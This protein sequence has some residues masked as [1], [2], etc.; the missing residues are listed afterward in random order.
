MNDI[1]SEYVSGEATEKS[2]TQNIVLEESTGAQSEPDYKSA[3]SSATAEYLK[4]SRSTDHQDL[5]QYELSRPRKI[6]I[7]ARIYHD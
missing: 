7:K 1:E 6:I 5:Q 3:D 2:T 4:H